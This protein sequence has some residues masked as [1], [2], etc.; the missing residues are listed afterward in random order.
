MA[1]RAVVSEVAL[2]GPG[3]EGSG[4]EGG[5]QLA[6]DVECFKMQRRPWN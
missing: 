4:G 3:V 2:P 1:A 6:S 5:L